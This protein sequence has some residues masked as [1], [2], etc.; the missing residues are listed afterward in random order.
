MTALLGRLI[1]ISKKR[2]F[3]EYLLDLNTIVKN[4]TSNEIENLKEENKQL[5]QIIEG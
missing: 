2:K 5:K 4:L 3:K 1:S